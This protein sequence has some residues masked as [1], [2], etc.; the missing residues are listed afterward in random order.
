MLSRPKF[1]DSGN[2][3]RRI[4]GRSDSGFVLVEILVVSIIVGILAVA[5]IPLYSGYIRSQRQATALAVAQTAAITASSI[6]RR[7]G[8]VPTSP[9]L[10]AAILLPN[11]A[12][13][14]VSVR[15]PAAG[16]NFVDVSE[17]SN[18]SVPVTASAQF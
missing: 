13:F 15:S 17:N 6:L 11:A 8:A 10:N 16:V 3:P 9:Q 2:R 4:W 12:Q 14:T 18:P 1:G 7:T 5:A